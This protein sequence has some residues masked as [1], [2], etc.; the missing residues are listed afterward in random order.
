MFIE[1]YKDSI[2]INKN[3]C[4]LVTIHFWKIIPHHWK[5]NLLSHTVQCEGVG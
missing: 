2:K 1:I 3:V 5:T 4:L